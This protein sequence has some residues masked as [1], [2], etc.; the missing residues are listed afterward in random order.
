[1]DKKS[2][3]QGKALDC[4]NVWRDTGNSTDVQ[5]SY[6]GYYKYAN[7]MAAPL[8][9]PYNFDSVTMAVDDTEPVQDVDDL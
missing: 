5:G 2:K 7:N 3:I 8:Y 4:V 6:T 1:M 9:A